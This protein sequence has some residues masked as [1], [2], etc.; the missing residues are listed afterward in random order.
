MRID[1]GQSEKLSYTI[2]FFDS[3]KRPKGAFLFSLK[4]FS[5]NIKPAGVTAGLMCVSGTLT[6]LPRRGGE[7]FFH[8]EFFCWERRNSKKSNRLLRSAGGRTLNSAHSFFSV[9]S[10]RSW[11]QPNR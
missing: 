8:R 5:K 11:E 4:I 2:R 1:E 7:R 10:S 9:P 3:L 6:V